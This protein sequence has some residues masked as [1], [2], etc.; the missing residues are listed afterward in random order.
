MPEYVASTVLGREK[1]GRAKTQ[2]DKDE[3]ARF[4]DVVEMIVKMEHIS[5]AS[6][7]ISSFTEEPT[8]RWAAGLR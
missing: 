6:T 5:Q 1:R 3:K 8:R 2:A 7:L 4:T